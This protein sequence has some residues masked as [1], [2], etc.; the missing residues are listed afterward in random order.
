MKLVVDGTSICFIYKILLFVRVK[1]CVVATVPDSQI[2]FVCFFHSFCCFLLSS[3][4][5]TFSHSIFHHLYLRCRRRRCCHCSL[6]LFVCYAD[7]ELKSGNL[8]QANEPR[9]KFNEK[10]EELKKNK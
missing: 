3:T 8:W 9:E 1:M 6:L 4:A 7:C 5:A 10:E 2:L